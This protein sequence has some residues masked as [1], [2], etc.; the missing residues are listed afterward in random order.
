MVIEICDFLGQLYVL[1]LEFTYFQGNGLQRLFNVLL[2]VDELIVFLLL[3]EQIFIER[4]VFVP[5]FAHQNLHFLVVDSVDLLSLFEILLNLV[6][7]FPLFLDLG[8]FVPKLFLRKV[9]F[10]VA[11]LEHTSNEELSVANLADITS[12]CSF[13]ELPSLKSTLGT[14]SQ[15]TI[16]ATFGVGLLVVI[17]VTAIALHL[18]VGTDIFRPFK[19]KYVGIWIK[20]E[21]F[22]LLPVFAYDINYESLLS[23]HHL[24]NMVSPCISSG[25][26][27]VLIK[28]H[29]ILWLPRS[30]FEELKET[31]L[32]F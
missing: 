26:I 22:L 15:G 29:V 20:L 19:F 30:F 21:D 23:N 9:D 31:V 4:L 6:Q 13:W 28:I 2:L 17:I 14:E 32:V 25:P 24:I 10:D 5:Q 16:F 27:V 11:F 12:S 8:R 7:F 1:H 18:L 3:T